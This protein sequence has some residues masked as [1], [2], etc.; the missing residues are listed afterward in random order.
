MR[1]FFA[2]A[3]CSLLAVL[4][5]PLLAQ[6]TAQITPPHRDPQAVSILRQ[7]LAA[8]GGA[9]A[10]SAVLDFT[11]TGKITYFWTEKG[12]T[13]TVVIKSRGLNQLR[14]EAAMPDGVISGVANNGASW[15]K[16]TDGTTRQ[17][18]NQHTDNAGTKFLPFAEIAAAL[19]EP[20]ISI[21]DLGMVTENG[22]QAH[23]IRLQKTFSGLDD[24]QHTRAKLM[25]RDIF[26]DPGTFLVVRTRYLSTTRSNPVP[27]VLHDVLF[28]DYQPV[29]GVLFP[30][31]IAE[32][33]NHQQVSTIKFDQVKFNN[34]LGDTDFQQ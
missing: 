4:P 2:V 15:S 33:I 9:Q 17:L 13:G 32:C 22:Q 10:L 26:I 3:V 20:S 18:S 12:E 19:A 5:V 8:A 34:S 29:N 16:E 30:L 25:Q 11:A 6:Q 23:G 27:S 31:S 24:Q 1:H 14:I 21:T 28:S 7:S